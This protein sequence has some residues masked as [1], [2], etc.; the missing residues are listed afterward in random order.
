MLTNM[1]DGPVTTQHQLRDAYR[2]VTDRVAQALHRAGRRPGDAILVAVTTGA[3]PDQ[4]RMLVEMGQLDLGETQ[5]QHLGQRVAQLSEFLHRRRQ[6]AGAA[7]KLTPVVTAGRAP[8][9]ASS[10]ESV[11]WHMIGPVERAKVRQLV[12]LVRLIHSTNSLRLAEEMHTFLGRQGSRTDSKTPPTVEILVQVNVMGDGSTGG[13]L[14]P[15]V[16]HVC[17][18]IDTMVHLRLR[19]LMTQPAP[20]S[21]EQTTQT[22][23]ARTADIF[24]EIRAAKNGSREFNIL[25]MGSSEN[26]ELAIE[27]GANIVRVG[28]ALFDGRG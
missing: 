28:K 11:R 8:G 25:S 5:V 9:D 4:I 12:P 16:R 20:G 22:I 23:F 26:F 21:D 15:A 3:T 2:R 6:L 24:R 17:D 10:N 18:Q 7:P 1:P 19:G 27:H 13:V 14:A